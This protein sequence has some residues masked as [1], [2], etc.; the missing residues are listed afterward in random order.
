MLLFLAEDDDCS[1]QTLDQHLRWDVV[2]LFLEHLAQLF[3]ESVGVDSASAFVINGNAHL[4]EVGCVLAG[5][6]HRET[7]L[8]GVELQ[9]VV[10]D[11]NQLVIAVFGLQVNAGGVVGK[12]FDIQRYLTA[13]GLHLCEMV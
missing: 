9:P 1:A 11:V 12:H 7:A 5:V 3:G 8:H 13:D 2:R 4:R 10:D 6:R